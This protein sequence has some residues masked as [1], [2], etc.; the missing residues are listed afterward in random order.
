MIELGP[1]LTG[2]IILVIVMLCVKLE[3]LNDKV[4][5]LLSDSIKALCRSLR[6]GSPSLSVEVFTSLNY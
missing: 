2:G 5:V 3:C 4:R 1:S 6:K